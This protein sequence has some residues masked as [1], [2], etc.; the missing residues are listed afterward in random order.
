MV[1]PAAAV[2]LAAQVVRLPQDKALPVE[3]QLKIRSA[4]AE[5]AEVQVQREQPVQLQPGVMAV[6]VLT[7]IHRGQ[8]QHPRVTAV[9][10]PEAVA[11]V[12]AHLVEVRQTVVQ[13]VPAA[14]ETHHLLAEIQMQK[15]EQLTPEAAAA[16]WF[17]IT[18]HYCAM[19][20][21]VDQVWSL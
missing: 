21:Q 17:R 16:V 8:V 19:A 10:T 7:L 14:A 15:P 11:V 1:D 9:I 2:H 5:E 12:M 20:V 4:V 18:H 13:V 3:A 6:L